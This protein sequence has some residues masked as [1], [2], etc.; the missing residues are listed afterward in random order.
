MPAPTTITEFL[1]LGY[2]SGLLDKGPIESL[3]Q[4]WRQ[5][6]RNLQAPREL[7]DELIR[8]GL[9][10][11]FQAEKL[12]AGRWRGFV[13]SG[14]YRLLALLGTGGMG[15]VYLCE[16]I[17]MGRRV[18]LKVLPRKQ[19]E[20]PAALALSSGGQGG[21]PARSSQHRPC[22]RHRPRGQAALHRAGVRGRL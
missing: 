6:H 15:Q 12:M 20:D 17:L 16:H 22:P 5:D 14:K 11:H 10:T 3:R 19:A 1:D 2:R 9:L 8:E 13:I 18:A 21:R 7:A 4:A